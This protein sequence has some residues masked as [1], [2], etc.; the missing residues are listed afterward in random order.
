MSSC[1]FCRIASRE[2]PSAELLDEERVFAFLD[3]NP[4]ARGHALLVPKR[5]APRLE[6]APAEDVAALMKAAQKLS[7]SLC[8]LTGNPDATIA[9][10]NGPAAGQEVQHLHIHIVPRNSGDGHGPIHALFGGTMKVP[11]DELHDLAI[12]VQADLGGH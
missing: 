8:K 10:N 2:L 4:L 1:L 5:H 12:L 7:R 6:D 11:P 9:I 3:I